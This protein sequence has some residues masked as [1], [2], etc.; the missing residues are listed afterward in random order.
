MYPRDIIVIGTSAG[1][2]QALQRLIADLPANLGASIFVVQHCSPGRSLLAKIL[3]RSGSLPAIS[4]VNHEAIRN[5]LIYVAPPDRHMLIQDGHVCTSQGPKENGSRPAI[6][7]LFRSAARSYGARVIGV[8]LTGNLDDGTAGLMAVK[9]RGG[10]AV[11]QS[12]EDAAYPS[13]PQSALKHVKTDYCLPISEIAAKLIQLTKDPV[14]ELPKPSFGLEAEY[15]ISL[16]DTVAIEQVMSLG[17]L[18]PFTCP[19]CQSVMWELRDNGFVR[20]RCRMGHAHT[21]QSLLASQHE[22]MENLLSSLDRVRREHTELAA[23]IARVEERN[24][25][26]WNRERLTKSTDGRLKPQFA[27]VP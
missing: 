24:G 5:G 17:T 26:T 16:G 8:V 23:Y 25:Q 19:E 10:I 15:R 11:V 2:V 4:P 1:G 7:A 14:G 6:D 18:S 9:E 20:F 3:G 22:N 12:P 27:N 21:A 13:M